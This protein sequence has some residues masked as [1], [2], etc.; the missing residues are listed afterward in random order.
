MYFL[1]LGEYI[2]NWR[3]RYFIL[4]SDGE[5]FG[6]KD[7]PKSETNLEPLNHF[8]VERKLL[9]HKILAQGIKYNFL[10][11]QLRPLIPL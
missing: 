10:Y 11:I 1:F 5:F 6:F 3:P 7:K 8:S 9:L 2:K 4:R